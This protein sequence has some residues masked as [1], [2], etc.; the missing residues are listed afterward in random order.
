MYNIY[1]VQCPVNLVL[2]Q[3]QI[4]DDRGLKTC[5]QAVQMDQAL[6]WPVQRLLVT[7]L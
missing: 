2:G 6:L 7:L 5:H 1:N 3:L 4:N